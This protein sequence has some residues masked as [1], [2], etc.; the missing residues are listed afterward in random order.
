[1]ADAV[2]A[3]AGII[4]VAGSPRSCRSAV[5]A[6]DSRQLD[7]HQDQVGVSLVREPDTLFPRLG[8]NDLVALERQ[9]VPHELAVLLVVLDDEDSLTRHDAP[10]A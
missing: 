10:G 4:R 7:I 5:G 3:S 6:V 2:T 8:L 9:Y 1:M